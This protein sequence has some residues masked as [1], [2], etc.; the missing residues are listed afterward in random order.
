MRRNGNQARLN[1]LQL[2]EITTRLPAHGPVTAQLE[3]RLEVGPSFG[4]ATYRS[5][6]EHWDTWLAGYSMP[7]P[8]GRA[9]R[10]FTSAEAV[11]NRVL[12]PPMVLWLPEALGATADVLWAAHDAAIRAPQNQPSQAAAIR[13]VFDWVEVRELIRQAPIVQSADCQLVER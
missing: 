2:L 7:G 8:Y 9:A 10:P 3:A 13:R 4:Q 12:C 6:K 11:Y 5:Q 1:H